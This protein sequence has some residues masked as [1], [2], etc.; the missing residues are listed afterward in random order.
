MHDVV[1]IF[2]KK[3]ANDSTEVCF[4]ESDDRGDGDDASI[5]S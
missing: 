3:I 5:L 1:V 4:E 2:L